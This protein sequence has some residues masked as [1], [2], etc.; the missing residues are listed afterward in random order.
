MTSF[1]VLSAATFS[2]VSVANKLIAPLRVRQ[3]K[4]ERDQTERLAKRDSEMLTAKLSLDGLYEL[5]QQNLVDL[6]D[7][8]FKA[9]FC[10]P[11]T[12]SIAR[13]KSETRLRRS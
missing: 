10:P 13:R 4:A 11:R 9:G 7:P 5:V 12:G 1:S 6:S 8:D 2:D 3:Q